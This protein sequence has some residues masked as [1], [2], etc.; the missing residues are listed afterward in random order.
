MSISFCTEP[1]D[2]PGL[3]KSMKAYRHSCTGIN[4]FPSRPAVATHILILLGLYRGK[5]EVVKR[6]EF[7]GDFD[8]LR[9]LTQLLLPTREMDRYIVVTPTERSLFTGSKVTFYG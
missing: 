2:L 5:V 3:E 9:Q 8:G 4:A 7:V 6:I 1:T